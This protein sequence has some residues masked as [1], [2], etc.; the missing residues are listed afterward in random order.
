MVAIILGTT[1]EVVIAVLNRLP[2]KTRTRV[3]EITLDIAESMIAKKCFT[4]STLVTERFHVQRL[5]L[6]GVQEIRIKHQ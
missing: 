1:S 5:A 6:E 2:V 4:N 3:K